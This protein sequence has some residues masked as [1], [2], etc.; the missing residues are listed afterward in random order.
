MQITYLKNWTEVTEALE[1][2]IDVKNDLRE[3]KGT[4]IISYDGCKKLADFCWIVI[5]ETPMFP[6]QPNVNNRQQHIWAMW[7]GYKWDNDRDNRL[8]IEGEAS[9]LN[10]GKIVEDPTN[11]WKTKVDE[12]NSV[13]SKYKSTMAY[14]RAYCKGIVRMTRLIGIYSDVEASDFQKPDSD[15]KVTLDYDAI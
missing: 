3:R 1:N 12:I 15:N 4:K 13:D 8:F 7:L 11:P 14:K 6:V 10:T 9:M 2:I 5:K